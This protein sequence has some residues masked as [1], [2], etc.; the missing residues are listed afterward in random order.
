MVYR[1]V[2]AQPEAYLDG[3][4]ELT[5]HDV[6]DPWVHL[7]P[8]A[9]N[10][11]EDAAGAADS[12]PEAAASFG[13]V[14]VDM[15][16]D[17]C[18]NLKKLGFNIGTTIKRKKIKD[19][20]NSQEECEDEIFKIIA[21]G[22]DGV[23][24]KCCNDDGEEQELDLKHDDLPKDWQKCNFKTQEVIDF[25][26]MEPTDNV[27]WGASLLQGAAGLALKYLYQHHER[28]RAS[29]FQ[30]MEKPKALKCVDGTFKR[31]QL[32]LT[33]CAR[34]VLLRKQGD[35]APANSINL[36]EYEIFGKKIVG[37]HV[38]GSFTYKGTAERMWVAP[39]WCVRRI[40]SND[41][42]SDPPNMTFETRDVPIWG[43]P[44][45]VCWK[46]TV[47]VMVNTRKITAD[48]E[49]TIAEWSTDDFDVSKVKRAVTGG[50]DSQPKRARIEDI[51]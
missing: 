23:H 25:S 37:L 3:L 38:V 29:Q 51:D 14:S 48:D 13:I 42:D 24:C 39:F 26:G 35:P 47:P 1:C 15:L 40:K 41:E 11:T 17:P 33:P 18:Y 19:P 7:K 16:K 5:G 49:V 8:A 43:G 9:G 2:T 36:G 32:V 20:T 27:A 31:G 22:T 21:M 28:Q 50:E 30:A 6:T 10:G 46:I 44:G 34:S 4:K 45:A 12:A